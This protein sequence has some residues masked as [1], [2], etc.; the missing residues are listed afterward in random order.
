[1]SDI[2]KAAGETVIKLT[3]EFTYNGA[4]FARELNFRA[5]EMT[6]P[7]TEKIVREKLN[8]LLGHCVNGLTTDDGL[9]NLGR[10]AER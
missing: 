10:M 6:V 9:A 4:R 7:Y 5:E 8:L 3:V 2:L 1:M